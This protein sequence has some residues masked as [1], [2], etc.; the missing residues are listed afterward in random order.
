LLYS[1]TNICLYYDESNVIEPLVNHGL[2]TTKLNSSF[3]KL[4]P[5]GQIIIST[6]DAIGIYNLL[7]KYNNNN[8]S[9]NVNLT[10]TIK[11]RLIYNIDPIIFGSS[12]ISVSYMY[13]LGGTFR[14]N[15]K[16]KNISFNE[17]GSIVFNN[18]YPAIYV[19]DIDY[20][21]NFVIEKIKVNIP[22]NPLFELNLKNIKAKYGIEFIYDK[23]I[24]KPNRGSFEINTGDIV[25]NNNKITIN[26][27]KFI[28]Q[29]DLTLKYIVNDQ[30]SCLNLQ[31]TIEPD[32]Y[33]SVNIITLNYHDD[34]YSIAP[35]INPKGGLF[36]LSYDETIGDIKININSGILFFS[37]IIFGKHTIQIKYS[38]N[39]FEIITDYIIIS[40]LFIHYNNLLMVNY[41]DHYN[42]TSPE[43]IIYPEGGIFS[44]KI[45]NN[46][47]I[48]IDKLSGCITVTDIEVGNYELIVIYSYNNVFKSCLFKFTVS[49][50]LTFETNNLNVI[51]NTSFMSVPPIVNPIGGYFTCENLI[52][53][54]ILNKITGVISF[55]KLEQLYKIN[56]IIKINKNIAK[57][58]TYN[59]IINYKFKNI[60]ISKLL[61]IN[62][63]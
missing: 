12:K 35:L 17:N 16:Y 29:Y 61:F 20:I 3:I 51:Q 18:A 28:G 14:F 52:D 38:I 2:F 40:E 10:I 53:G 60:T 50:S 62:I 43:P 9:I 23:I 13:P 47:N 5:N 56:N 46:S 42:I 44:F 22:V 7:I 24:V 33:Y 4:N 31:L 54:L 27:N 58:N 59:I 8:H 48:I 11:P 37:K 41:Q 36:S 39:E 30:I 63:I 55:L 25:I 32:F 57:K 45:N 15:N 26:K 49:P 19:F 1:E 34:I 6:T 21:F